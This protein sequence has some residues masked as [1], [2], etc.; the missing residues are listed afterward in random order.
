MDGGGRG[1]AFVQLQDDATVTPVVVLA[2]TEQA[3][4]APTAGI[5][6]AIGRGTLGK[7]DSRLVTGPR[8]PVG[9]IVVVSESVASPVQVT[10]PVTLTPVAV[11]VGVTDAVQETVGSGAATEAGW[12][13][14]GALTPATAAEA[15][16]ASK[17]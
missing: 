12:A 4:V 2:R 6:V 1:D 14:A 3:A 9:L 8:M 5:V 16:M 17:G 11:T 13:E 7:A 15:A 10:L